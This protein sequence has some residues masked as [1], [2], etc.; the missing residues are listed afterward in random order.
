MVLLYKVG[1]KLNVPAR[2]FLCEDLDELNNI[3]DPMFG[4]KAT[5]LTSSVPYYYSEKQSK[6]VF[7]G[8][9]ATDDGGQQ[10]W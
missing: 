5:V 1:D 2:E 10:N 8:E 6:W 9:S 3:S 7:L 4:D